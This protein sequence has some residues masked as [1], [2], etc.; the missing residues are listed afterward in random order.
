MAYDDDRPTEEYLSQ[1]GVG[2]DN[3]KESYIQTE[4]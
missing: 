3:D 1:T 4:I 2:G